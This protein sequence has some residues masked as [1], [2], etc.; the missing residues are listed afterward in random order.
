MSLSKQKA[1][2]LQTWREGHQAVR[3]IGPEGGRHSERKMEERQLEF[4]VHMERE[5]NGTQG[6]SHLGKVG[7]QKNSGPDT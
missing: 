7:F 2:A 3:G 6:E 1:P 5:E 4:K